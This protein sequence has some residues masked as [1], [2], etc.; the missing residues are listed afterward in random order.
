VEE[1]FNADLELQCRKRRPR[2]LRGHTETTGERFERDRAA[3]LTLPSSP[4]KACEKVA[5]RVSSLALVR[6]RGNDYSVATRHGHLQV[7][8]RGHVHEVTIACG[9]E[10]IAR[11]AAMNARRSST[12]RCTTL[13]CSRW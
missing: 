13:H 9:S 12:I 7:L 5:A 11:H 3:L 6:Y 10:I 1:G 4:Y 2:K 8:V